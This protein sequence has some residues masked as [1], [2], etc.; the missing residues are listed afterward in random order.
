MPDRTP[1]ERLLDA[2][3]R[4]RTDRPPVICTGGMMNAA[5]VGVM[6]ETGHT[7]PRGHSD[8]TAMAALA[9][10]VRDFTGFE[11]IG[12]PFC[13]TV[14]AEALG[15]EVDLGTLGCEPKIAKERF[16]SVAEAVV[17]APESV[18]R[19][20]RIGAVAGAVELLART[21]R[22]TPIVGNVSGPISTAAS[23]VDP[24]SFLKEL[25]KRPDE[26]HRVLEAV[27]DFLAAYAALLVRRGATLICIGDPTATGEIL[28]P[29]MFEAYAVPYLNRVVDAIHGAGSHVIVHICGDLKRVL[30][31]VP[32]LRSDAISTD[33]MVNLK[34]LKDEYPQ[35]VTMGNLST[36]TL[37]WGDAAKVAGRARQLVDDGIDI[38]SPACGLSTSTPLANIRAMTAA[39]R[40]A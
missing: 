38:V 28:G 10:D 6:E 32:R 16:A 24:M 22:D 13:L 26:A 14:E 8:G 34:A 18:E 23:L 5:I 9:R 2:L 7:L 3:E 40:E 17:A 35:L 31:L 1:K 20:G 15:S 12:L 21:E 27:A 33:A 36:Y 37:Q 25:R 11:N 39:V 29:K 19:L 30:P 4:K